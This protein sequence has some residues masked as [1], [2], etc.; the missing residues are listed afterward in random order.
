VV[1]VVVVPVVVTP[2]KAPVA[3]EVTV[4]TEKHVP[5]SSLPAV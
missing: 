1:V 4:P 3:P 5:A 2:Y